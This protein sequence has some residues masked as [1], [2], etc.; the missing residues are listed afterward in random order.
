ME[1]KRRLFTVLLAMALVVSFPMALM[2][3]TEVVNPDDQGSPETTQSTDDENGVGDEIVVDDQSS[4]DEQTDGDDQPFLNDQSSGDEQNGDGNRNGEGGENG[5]GETGDENEQPDPNA[6]L[7][8]FLTNH[9]EIQPP[10]ANDD[11]VSLIVDIPNEDA[12]GISEFDLINHL[13]IRVTTDQV[14]SNGYETQYAFEETDSGECLVYTTTR[15]PALSKDDSVR[16]QFILTN[17]EDEE[18]EILPVEKV[19]SIGPA[20]ANAPFQARKL[21][22]TVTPKTKT[23][24]YNGTYRKPAVTIVAKYNGTTIPQAALSYT[25]AYSHS[26][27]AG[28]ATVTVT[29]TGDYTG[30]ASAKY[31]INKAANPLNVAAK[32]ATV[33]YAKVKKKAQTL[34]VGSVI[35]FKKK[36][37]GTMSYVKKSGNAKIT[38]NKKTGKVTVKKGLKKGTYKIKVQVKAGGNSNY[39][40]SAAKNVTFTVKV[41]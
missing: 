30:T 41:K 34:A 3:E 35:N 12:D 13:K 7:V 14:N 18:L 16:A 2:A 6:L 29:L 21:T 11:Y 26:M 31:T 28:T 17:G 36:G 27:A 20:F 33:K 37:Q 9:C 15:M 24:T 25:L 4:G 10:E 39:K 8:E 40:A 23:Y 38:I 5:S 19:A 32:T 1:L 22:M